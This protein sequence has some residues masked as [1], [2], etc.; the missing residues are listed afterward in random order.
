[1]ASMSGMDH[2]K[3]MGPTL[4]VISTIVKFLQRFCEIRSRLTKELTRAHWA[5]RSGSAIRRSQPWPKTSFT[6]W[7]SIELK[8]LRKLS[9]ERAL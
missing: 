3:N 4:F 6:N 2:V 1:M 8:L 7:R 5:Q 9:E